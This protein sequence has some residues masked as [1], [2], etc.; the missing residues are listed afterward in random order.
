M[1]SG[2][3]SKSSSSEGV[4]SFCRSLSD[5]VLFTSSLESLSAVVGVVLVVVFCRRRGV[6]MIS[7]SIRRC[8]RCNC[9]SM[10][11]VNVRAALPYNAVGVTVP[12][13]SC[14]R[15]LRGYVLLVSSCRSV[16]NFFHEAAMRL[17]SSVL[18]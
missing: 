11:F 7:L 10:S 15:D 17:S 8:V 18:L 2:H 14:S 16:W 3:G 12:S 5:V 4:M 13:K 9:F 1:K 6:L